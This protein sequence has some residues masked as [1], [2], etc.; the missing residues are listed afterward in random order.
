ETA[1]RVSKMGLRMLMQNLA[2]EMAPYGVRVNMVTPGHFPTRMTAGVTE[3]VEQKLLGIIPAHRFGDPLEV[4]NAA[5]F[6][7]SDRLSGYTYGADLVIDGGL[8]LN[9]LPLYTAEEIESFNQQR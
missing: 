2:I 1:Y 6:L 8:T 5:V 3:A 4:G 9:P 7:L